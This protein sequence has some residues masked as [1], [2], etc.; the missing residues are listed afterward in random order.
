MSEHIF[1]PR[2][3]HL[4]CP[5]WHC[6][7]LISPPTRRQQFHHQL[8]HQRQMDCHYPPRQRHHLPL[9]TR[10]CMPQLSLHQ[11]AVHIG[12]GNGPNHP[13]ALQRL[14]KRKVCHA[15]VACKGQAMTGHPSDNQSQ[16]MVRSNII[17]NC[18]VK[19]KH[20]VN[21]NSIFGPS[22]AGVRGKTIRCKPD[23]VEAAPGRIPNDFHRLHKFVVL[24]ADVMFVNGI[25]FLTTLS[26]KLRLAT[27]KQL[28]PR[29]LPGS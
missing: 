14:H 11:H 18:P 28:P 15:I 24:T 1:P 4:A 26:Q 13:P 16:A 12:H 27:I 17:K 6:Q 5:Q 3:P 2:F 23:Q 22:I 21:T 8:P 25:V 20:I 7:S 29:A 9:Q 10:W 19:P